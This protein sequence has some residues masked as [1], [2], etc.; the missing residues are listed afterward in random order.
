[1]KIVF[2]WLILPFLGIPTAF[3]QGNPEVE[4]RDEK[5]PVY[6][7]FQ[8]GQSVVL[9]DYKNNKEV[10]VEIRRIV[11]KIVNDSTLVLKAVQLC[12]FA[13]PEG[14]YEYNTRLSFDRAAALKNYL[15]ERYPI[16]SPLIEVGCKSED[17]EGL[18]A[19]VIA[20]DLPAR[21]EIRSI[22]TSICDPDDREAWIWQIDDGKTYR[23]LLNRYYPLLRRVECDILYRNTVFSAP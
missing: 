10:L 23:I 14:T 21:Q 12:G 4:D 13:S 3:G 22:I 16:D 7:D 17:W 2:L 5:I 8:V 1:M 19:L 15:L 20:S 6:L 11:E 9:P 18:H